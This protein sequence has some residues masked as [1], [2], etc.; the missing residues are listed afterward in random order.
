MVG[1]FI[2]D[3]LGDRAFIGKVTKIAIPIII[4]NFIASTLNMVDTIIIGGLGETQIAAVGIANQYFFLFSLI[5]LGIIGG[6]G[7]FIAQFWGKR[8]VKNI[9]KFLGVGLAGV[10]IVGTLFTIAALAFPEYIIMIFNKDPMVVKEGARY[11]RI[12]SISYIFTVITFNYASALR[13]IEKPGAPMMISAVAIVLNGVLD[14]VL[15]YGYMG[16]PEMGVAGAAIATVIARVIEMVLIIFYVYASRSVIAS[17]FRDV[18]DFD[19]SFIKNSAPV[20]MPVVLNETC[21]AFGNVFYVIAYGRLGTDAIAAIQICT[22]I[23]N[24]FLVVTLGMA[25]AAAVMIGN[26]IGSGK[27]EEAKLFGKRFSILAVLTGMFLGG[28]LALSAS[29]VVSLFNVSSQVQG[30][31]IKIL[32]VISL[33][34]FLKNFNTVFAIGILQGGG[35]SGFSFR[36]QMFTMWC[37]GVPL[38]FLGAA[39]LKIPIYAV[40]A[41]VC[42]EEIVKAFIGIRRLVTFKWVK[43][44]TKCVA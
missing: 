18:F 20:I 32:Y 26:K 36:I 35:D 41:L 30:N 4:Q 39:V 33:S 17:G 5:A 34:M 3:L 12:V 44:V 42:V 7:I 23:Q 11:L 24:M 10:T 1:T 43:N 14:Y 22:T 38:A 31:A 25:S 13:C 29:G 2:S 15:V 16:A 21:W 9:R 6:C 40:V 28:I 8:D 19:L 37:I 27:E